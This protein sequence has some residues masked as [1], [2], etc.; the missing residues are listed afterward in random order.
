MTGLAF[1]ICTRGLTLTFFACFRRIQASTA[2]RHLQQFSVFCANR[3]VAAKPKCGHLFVAAIISALNL[4][5]AINQ[6]GQLCG[7]IV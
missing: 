2:C 3:I 6:L 7:F 5:C 4:H 1:A